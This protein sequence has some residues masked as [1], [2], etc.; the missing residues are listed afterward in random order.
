MLQALGVR[1]V[2]LLSN[3][4]DKAAQLARLGLRVAHRVPTAVHLS[5]AN[6]RYLSA[7]AG[8][9]RHTLELLPDLDGVPDAQRS[10]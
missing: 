4:P 8:R 10:G 1:T 3:N 9:G 2:A 6:S 7:K 5:A